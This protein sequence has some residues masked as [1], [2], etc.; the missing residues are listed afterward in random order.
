MLAKVLSDPSPDR[1]G[2]R[3]A[4]IA[5]WRP[6]CQTRC[7]SS[8]DR[9][10]NAAWRGEKRYENRVGR[11]Y[12]HRGTARDVELSRPRVVP[13]PA[14]HRGLT[15]GHAVRG[16]RSHVAHRWPDFP[17]AGRPRRERAGHAD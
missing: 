1:G 4:L 17:E 14:G 10:L 7:A 15:G 12:A 3:H 13:P 6:N 5:T 9:S 16:Q 8:L 2:T 11:R